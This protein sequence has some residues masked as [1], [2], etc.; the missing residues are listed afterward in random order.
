MNYLKSIVSVAFISLLISCNSEPSLQKYIVDN[1]ENGAFVSVDLPSNILKLKNGEVSEDVEKTLKT[2]QKV[3]FLA[4]Q[5]TD[6]TK[7]L[8]T[9]E[10][11]K[12]KT[13]VKNPMYKQL[14]KVHKGKGDLTIN[15]LGDETN[16]DEVVIFGSENSKGFAIIRVLGE[17]MNPADI[18]KMTKDIQLDESSNGLG[19]IGDLIKNMY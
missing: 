9:L 2:I 18:A 11:E 4:L 15:Y 7:E 14:V 16:I 6:S 19:Q 3:N 12:V 1:K 5:L 13:I 10:K 8:Y 17:N